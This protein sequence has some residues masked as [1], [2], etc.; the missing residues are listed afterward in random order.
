MTSSSASSSTLPP[1]LPALIA[2]QYDQAIANS[3]AFFYPSEIHTVNDESKDGQEVPL[4]WSVRRCE[5]LRQKA[6]EKKQKESAASHSNGQQSS[7]SGGQN[8]SDVF[9]PPY[10]Q[11]CEFVP[12][13]S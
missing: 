1:N 3:A 12:K 2:K 13:S 7:S 6:L 10:D 8:Q 11:D 5:A 9:A 4:Q